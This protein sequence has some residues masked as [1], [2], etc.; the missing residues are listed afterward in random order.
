M[1]K[2][3][4]IV[5]S[6]LIVSV[7]FTGCKKSSSNDEV[8]PPTP[9]PTPPPVETA[10]IK[11]H[12]H[13]VI[14]TAIGDMVLSP[15]FR[16]NVSYKNADGEMVNVENVSL[17]W[18]SEEMTVTKPFDALIEGVMLFNEEE[19][20]DTVVYGRLPSLYIDDQLVGLSFAS[21]NMWPKAGF[22]NMVTEH[23]DRLNFNYSRLISPSGN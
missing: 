17:P 18:T 21:M 2:V 12:V 20:P 1:R 19:L 7:L 8:V 6:L 5:V 3:L 10:V 13:T 11:Y 23:P 16:A 4:F 9:Q 14:H 22:I 15:C